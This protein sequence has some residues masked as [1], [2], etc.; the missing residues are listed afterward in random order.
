MKHRFVCSI[1]VLCVSLFLG[2]LPLAS[3]S[4]LPKQRGL[5]ADRHEIHLSQLIAIA[6]KANPTIKVYRLNWEAMIERFP[7]ATALDDPMFQFGYFIQS[8]ETRVGPQERQYS[9]VQK[10]PFPGKLKAKGKIVSK[11]VEIARVKLDQTIREV[12]TKLKDAYYELSYLDKAIEI[13]RQNQ[14]VVAHLAKLATTG[15]DLDGTTLDDVFK[16]ESQR[17]QLSYDLIL[18][19]EF[20]ETQ[21]TRI[22]GLLNR[23]PEVPLGRTVDMPHRPLTDTVTELYQIGRQYHE[24][25]KMAGLEIALRAEEAHLAGMK[26]LP[27]FSFG[28]HYTEVGE[29]IVQSAES[30]KDAYKVN[31]GITL[32][33]WFEKNRARRKEAELRHQSAGLQREALERRLLT[34]IKTVY[35]KVQNAERQ[36]QLYRG[37]L[38][39]QAQQSISIA[40]TWVKEKQGSF[41][42]L[43]E[44]QSV[45]LNFNLALQRAIANH[46]Q[47]LAKL[48]KLIGRNL[49]VKP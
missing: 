31:V 6:L 12:L 29:S 23:P 11:G 18:L 10:I 49:E 2:G 48:E 38:I 16:A 26:A 46:Q 28:L 3:P 9:I 7:Q 30:G 13:T 33:L 27:N 14:E 22:N 42:G 21:L 17:A 20:R 45:W 35:F 25:L 5:E 32:P 36:I 44:M 43:L 8:V 41:S 24:G 15:Y 37:S 4:G 40:E 47:Y 34:E 1:I 19:S 39:P